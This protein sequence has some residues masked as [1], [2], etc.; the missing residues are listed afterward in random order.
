[1]KSISV[2][3]ILFTVCTA[4]S[5][6]PAISYTKRESTRDLFS[7]QKLDSPSWPNVVIQGENQYPAMPEK[8]SVA[9]AALYSFLLPGMGELYTG[10]YTMG[11]YFTIAEGALWITLLGVDRYAQWLQDDA[12]QYAAQHA[13]A[14][15]DGKDE[16]FFIDIGNDSDVY[17]F[18]QRILQN[19]DQFKIYNEALNSSD[20]WKWDTDVNRSSYR[21]RR[22]SSNEMFNNTRFIAAVIAVNHIVSAINAARLAI[23]YNKNIDHAELINIRA[24]LV[25]SLSHPDGMMITFSKNF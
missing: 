13:G 14:K 21:D 12:Y 22:V 19:R 23:S 8:K 2:F 5:Q 20:Y 24:R 25:G 17:T 7:S 11:K 3:L 18:N 16:Q 4:H 9:T 15:I 10:N 1:M 6:H